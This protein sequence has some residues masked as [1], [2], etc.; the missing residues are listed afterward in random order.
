M[1][2][3]VGQLLVNDAL[4]E[5]MRVT[6]QLTKTS[7]RELFGALARKYPDQYA[8]ILKRVSDVSKEAATYYGGVAS[9]GL[10]DLR[11]PPRMQAYRKDLRQRVHAIGQRRDLTPRQKND[12]IV[13][14]VRKAMP[15][16]QG[17]LRTEFAGRDNAY[18]EAMT[19]GYK[20]NPTQ[21]MQMVFGDMLVADHK[22]RP[23]PVPGL[24][25]Y[26]EGTTPLEYFGSSYG[27]RKAF[28]DVQFATAKT[29]FLGKQLAL[30][31]HRIQVTGKD[32]ETDNGIPV[33]GDDPEIIGSVLAVD[34]NGIPAGTTLDKQHL[35]TL[36]GS[37]PIVRSVA[38]CQMPEGVCQ[39]CSG[40]RDGDSFPPIDTYLGTHSARVVAEPM[41]QELGL[42]SKHSGGVVGLNDDNIEGFEEIEQFVQ[43]PKAFR[44]AATLAPI[45][46]KILNIAKAPQGG[47]Y[48]TVGNER[49][50]IPESRKV[51]VKVGDE[52][53]AGD[54]LTSGTPNPAEV[55]QHKGLGA[56]RA[57]FIEKFH[58][59][60]KDNG[61]AT[62]RRNVETLSRGFFDRVRIT[63]PDGVAGN[64]VGEVALY[65]D[66]QRDW[67]P[68]A[69][70]LSV[71]PRRAVGMYLER[72]A[73]YY[74]IGTRITPSVAKRLKENKVKT[75]DA[76]KDNPGFEPA[77]VRLMGISATDPDW[78]TRTAG[79]YLKRSMLDSARK[80]S[81]SPHKS[82]SYV[83]K[84]MDPAKL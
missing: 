40:K 43:V 72:P 31:A 24:H 53:E 57:Y 42:A 10:E 71:S 28:A 50:H 18:A 47:Q 25:S 2:Q 76:H 73:L 27:A 23:V 55:A 81:V 3:T 33:R 26:G 21:F 78:K 30:M 68:R 63:S 77:V 11:L 56:G 7:T 60:L 74:T 12:A 39:L 17:M 83:G 37:R 54:T 8:D 6:G 5:D 36:R 48:M 4:P 16:V 84:L 80:G 70:H 29:G 75:V 14:M 45:D 22:G 61:V 20:G 79:F 46:G 1:P 69:G 44:G 41:V 51:Q 32:C 64:R 67:K 65:S 82:T 15:V 19:Q 13:A 58:E 38:A 35:A 59:I 34:T 9:L 62:N 66:I 49:L 52:V